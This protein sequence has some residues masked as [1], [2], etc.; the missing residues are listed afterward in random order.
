M[1]DLKSRIK[2]ANAALKDSAPIEPAKMFWRDKPGVMGEEEKRFMEENPD[3]KG[4]ILTI[5]WYD[6][7]AINY[8]EA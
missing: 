6:P 1:S 5:C 8:E 3:F 4:E 2:K 7:N